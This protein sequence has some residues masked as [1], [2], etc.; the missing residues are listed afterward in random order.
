[1]KKYRIFKDNIDKRISHY[2]KHKKHMIETSSRSSWI[3]PKHYTFP[4]ITAPIMSRTII[5]YNIFYK[6]EEFDIFQVFKTCGPIVDIFILRNECTGENKNI[7]YIE[8]YS[9]RDSLKA[10]GLN[11]CYLYGKMLKIKH[12]DPEFE[13]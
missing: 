7:C 3:Y 9:L 8:F 12:I 11:D 6:A 4:K 2:I 5:V 13:K 1:M 10:A